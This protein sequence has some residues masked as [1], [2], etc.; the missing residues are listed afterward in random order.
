MHIMTKIGNIPTLEFIT[1]CICIA[2]AVW[3]TYYAFCP[4][5]VLAWYGRPWHRTNG[6]GGDQLPRR[7]DHVAVV[8]QGRSIIIKINQF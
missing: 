6:H 3:T 8:T 7:P 2:Q 4:L 5:V 1:F